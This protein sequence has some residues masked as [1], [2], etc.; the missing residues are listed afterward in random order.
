[1]VWVLGPE[2]RNPQH[3]LRSVSFSSED[4]MMVAGEDTLWRSMSIGKCGLWIAMLGISY[5]AQA[6]DLRDWSDHLAPVAHATV[7]LTLVNARY[8]DY[9]YDGSSFVGGTAVPG[10]VEL[11]MSEFNGVVSPMG[12]PW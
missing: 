6:T 11:Q 5:T 9:V 4:A 8:M 12:Q 7:G 3:V 10:E 2:E 1:M